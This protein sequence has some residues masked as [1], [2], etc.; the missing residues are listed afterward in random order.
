MRETYHAS[1]QPCERVQLV[2]PGSPELWYLWLG[3]CDTAEKSERDDKEGIEEHGD[4]AARRA[5]GDH[6]AQSHREEFCNK[7]DQELIACT[8][9]RGLKSGHVVEG[10][11]KAHCAKNAVGHLRKDHRE[12]KGKLLVCFCSGFSIEN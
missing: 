9:R 4:K 7:D 8:T 2:Q 5:S 12:R 3:D 10:K 1:N 6:L 11:E